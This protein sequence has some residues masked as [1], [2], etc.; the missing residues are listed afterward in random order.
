MKITYLKK[1]IVKSFSIALG[2]I[3]VVACCFY[4]RIHQE[5]KSKEKIKAIES[6]T[7]D[8][9]SEIESLQN[10]M[11]EIKKY[12]EIWINISENKKSLGGIKID[13]INAKLEQIGNKHNISQPNIRV[14]FPENVKDGIFNISS[15]DL[16]FSSVN[17]TFTAISDT[18]ALIFISDLIQSLPGYAVINKL[19]IAKTKDY[20]NEDLIKISSGSEGGSIVSSVDFFWY[21]YKPKST[22]PE[23]V[24]QNN[25]QIKQAESQ[26]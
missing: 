17:L 10:K 15:S 2:L 3:A 1:R 16:V 13:N 4:Y 7:S 20:T 18:E 19:S 5:Q 11:Q 23:E 24:K 9:R 26:I 12:K 25:D 6:S 14:S 8:V 21:V 22:N